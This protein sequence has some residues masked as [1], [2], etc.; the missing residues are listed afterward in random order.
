MTD[1]LEGFAQWRD[2]IETRVGTLEVTVEPEADAKARMSKDMSKLEVQYDFQQKLLEALRE[3]QSEHTA[4][5]R[6]HGDILQDHTA[7][8]EKLEVGQAKVLVGVE[9]IIGLLGR[10]ID[11]G[12][13]PGDS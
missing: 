2:E 1:D 3:T 13:Q 7:R 5:L 6:E 8:L 12:A 10:E 9:T 4:M 11:A